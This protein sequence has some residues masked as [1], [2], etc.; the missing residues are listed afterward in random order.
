MS[1]ADS[2]NKSSLN[3]DVEYIP[4]KRVSHFISYNKNK[5]QLDASVE[6]LPAM[7]AKF[8]SRIEA[9]KVLEV[10]V[11]IQKTRLYKH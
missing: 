1:Y 4:T 7:F 11:F 3:I 6:F 8:S 2:D 10:A 5:Q 9:G